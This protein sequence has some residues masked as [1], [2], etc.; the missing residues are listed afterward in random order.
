[1]WRLDGLRTNVLTAEV[2]DNPSAGKE[3]VFQAYRLKG[4]RGE[5]V[6]MRPMAAK[7]AVEDEEEQGGE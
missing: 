6:A 7:V 5:G 1:M 3:H 2:V 4:A